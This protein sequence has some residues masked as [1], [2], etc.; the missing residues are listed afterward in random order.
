M[1]DLPENYDEFSSIEKIEWDFPA[2]RGGVGYRDASEETI[3]YNCLSWALGINW[4]R[5]D[6]E[7]KCAGYYWF[8]GIPRKWDEPTIR[9]IFEKHSYT[10]ADNY[11]LEPEFEKVVFYCD[12]KGV[13]Q[14]FARQL[15][16]GKW[17]S[18]MGDL[19]DIEHDTLESLISELYGK[20]GLVLK[21]KLTAPQAA[22]QG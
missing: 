11:D 13:P 8:P 4:T 17:A 16:D 20:P 15:P 7:P 21:R 19:N 1:T 2:L 3:V 22:A 9:T 18:K 5:L 6:P 14:H 10:V 12:D